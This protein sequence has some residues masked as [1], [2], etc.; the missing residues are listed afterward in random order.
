MAIV[1]TSEASFERTPIPVGNHVARCFSMVEIGTVSGEYQGVPNKN[2][3]VRI[4]WELTNE[5]KTYTNKEGEEITRNHVI[6]KTYTLSLGEKAT[7][8]KD[9]D[10]WR[11]QPFTEEQ[12]RAFDITKLLNVPCMINVI[13]AKSKAGKDYEKIQTI[14]TMPKGFPAPVAVNEVFEL[15]YSE[16][17]VEKFL[18]LHSFIRE[19]MEKTPEFEAVKHIVDIALKA[20]LAEEDKNL[21]FTGAE[22]KPVV[23]DQNDTDPPF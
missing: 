8:R 4:T 1:A 12:A 3:K 16:F 2:R 7:L 21:P 20:Q 13:A 11:G 5:T 18:S 15:N 9:L 10:S 6:S 17:S 23:T 19:D 14:A 22:E